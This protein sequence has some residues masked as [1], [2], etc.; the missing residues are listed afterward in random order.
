[1]QKSFVIM[2]P[3]SDFSSLCCLQAL[4]DA[5]DDDSATGGPDLARHIFPV[6]TTITADGFARLPEA[7]VAEVAQRVVSDR[8]GSPDGPIASLRA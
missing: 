7:E 5:A 8:M 4:Y 3:T 2:A 6:V 1:V